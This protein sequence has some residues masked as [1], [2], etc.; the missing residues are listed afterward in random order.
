M[1]LPYC[2]LLLT[3]NLC[4]FL[5]QWYSFKSPAVPKEVAVKFVQLSEDGDTKEFLRISREKSDWIFVQL[6]HSFVKCVLTW[7][8]SRTSVNGYVLEVL[9]YVHVCILL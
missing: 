3:D 5:L 4:F 7:F 2:R 8:M 1:K 6:F 9:Y